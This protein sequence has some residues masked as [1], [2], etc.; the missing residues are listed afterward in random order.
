[1]DFYTCRNCNRRVNIQEREIHEMSCNNAFTEDEFKDMIPC[2]ICGELINYQNYSEHIERCFSFTSIEP[3]NLNIVGRLDSVI[4][5]LQN[6][7]NL[8]LPE[9]SDNM[10]IDVVNNENTSDNEEDDIPPLEDVN[11]N[12]VNENNLI[13]FIPLELNQNQNN[14]ENNEVSDEIDNFMNSILNILNTG[15]NENINSNFFSGTPINDDY[16]ELTNLSREIGNVEIGIENPDEYF[17]KTVNIGFKCPICYN[18]CENT[19][20]TSCNHEICVDCTKEWYSKNKKCVICMNEL[21]K[22]K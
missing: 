1:M 13:N 7:V 5:N 2:E 4:N 17:K 20:I 14:G 12:I 16:T 6:I 9:N 8:N 22:I 18:V 10:E 19:M 15:L 11:G 21:N 3:N